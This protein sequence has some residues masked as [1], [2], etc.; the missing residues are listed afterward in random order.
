MIDIIVPTYNRP[1]DIEKFVLEIQKQ[2]FKDYHV[3][4]ID[5]C[6]P[7]QIEHLIPKNDSRFSYFRLPENKGQAFARN[8]AIEKGVGEIIV[9]MDD[10]AWFE[11]ENAFS[12]LNDYFKKYSNLGC[13]M[14]DVRTPQEDYLSKIHAISTDG[15]IIGSHI[16]CGC[17]YSRKALMEIEGFGGYLHSGAEETD[18]T[19]KLI[20][21]GYD[22]RFALL[23]PVFHNYIP[24]IRSKRWYRMLRFNTTRNDLL[25]VVMRYPLVYVLPYFFGKYFSH[26]LFSVKFNRDRIAAAFYTLLSLPA[27]IIKLPQ[28]IM[29]RKALSVHDFNRWIKIRW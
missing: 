28:A 11:N 26:V 2:N 19:L 10:D 6:G 3:F 21:K 12:H 9:S 14:F 18:V 23:I 22:L 27:A 8:I 20:E 7:E 24:G 1:N 17:A 15:Q 5:D 13:L 29:H 25:I 16:T 4:I